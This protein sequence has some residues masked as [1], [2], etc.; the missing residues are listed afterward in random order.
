MKAFVNGFKNMGWASAV[1]AQLSSDSL[2]VLIV[3]RS[4]I[5][6]SSLSMSG[7]FPAACFLHLTQT[8]AEAPFKMSLLL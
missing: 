3:L 8:R 2:S 7:Y 5:L 1:T 6:D 4:E